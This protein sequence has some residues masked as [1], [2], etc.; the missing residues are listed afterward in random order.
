M[1]INEPQ[2]RKEYAETDKKKLIKRMEE[3]KI[4]DRKAQKKEEKPPK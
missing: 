3:K 1:N 2:F 4:L